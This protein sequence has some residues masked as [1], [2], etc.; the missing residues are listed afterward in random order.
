MG[1]NNTGKNERGEKSE[2]RKGHRNE[3]G[4]NQRRLLSDG[5]LKRLEEE[6]KV[7]NSPKT[8]SP[9]SRGRGREGGQEQSSRV[10][11]LV[12]FPV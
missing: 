7:Y 8:H 4:V 10:I 2:H 11:I 12:P 5:V 9:S 6:A 1:G 3:T